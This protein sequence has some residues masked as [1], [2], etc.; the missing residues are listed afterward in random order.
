MAQAAVRR[1]VL[2]RGIVMFFAG[3]VLRFCVRCVLGSI[4]NQAYFDHF[5]GAILNYVD[6]GSAETRRQ[7]V[8]IGVKVLIDVSVVVD[9]AFR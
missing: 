4:D 5:I 3:G 1:I 2:L 8:S 9:V 6:T 7:Q